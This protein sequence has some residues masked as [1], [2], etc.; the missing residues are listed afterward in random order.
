MSA[1]PRAKRRNTNG[2]SRMGDGGRSTLRVIRLAPATFETTARPA[3][4]RKHSYSWFTRGREYQICHVD[5][6]RTSHPERT[7]SRW[8]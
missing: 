3:D 6:K 1:P 2:S 7:E 8:V 4:D 5:V